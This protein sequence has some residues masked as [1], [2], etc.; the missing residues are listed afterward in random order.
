[1][2]WLVA[3]E[4]GKQVS[5]IVTPELGMKR[6]PPLLPGAVSGGERSA[7]RK[8]DR[9]NRPQFHALTRG[10]ILGWS[11]NNKNFLRLIRQIA[12][13]LGNQTGKKRSLASLI[14]FALS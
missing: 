8:R 6:F 12:N 13:F 3:C 11:G 2:S 4:V 5:A 9:G 7:Q 14:C 10:F 1:M